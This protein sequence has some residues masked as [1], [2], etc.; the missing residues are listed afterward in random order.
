MSQDP[1]P[2]LLIVLATW[3]TAVVAAMHPWAS[4]GAAFGCFFFLSVSSRLKRSARVQLLI[5]SWGIGYGAGIYWNGD[6]PARQGAMLVA[7]V[8]AALGSAL[9][10][11]FYR[12][13]DKDGALPP[14]LGSVLDRLPFTRKGPPNGP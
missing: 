10:T 9:F 2:A 3:I 13:I 6:D 4:T 11:A 7:G 8:A 12:V 1:A 5:F 14:W